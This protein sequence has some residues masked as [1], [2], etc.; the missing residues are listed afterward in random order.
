M[1]FRGLVSGGITGSF[2]LVLVPHMFARRRLHQPN[3]QYHFP[4]ICHTQVLDIPTLWYLQFD[5]VI[6]PP[7]FFS[8]G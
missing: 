3:A 6:M 4:F 8:S 5:V 7:P 1:E 2:T